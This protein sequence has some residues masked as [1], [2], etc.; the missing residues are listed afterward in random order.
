MVGRYVELEISG[1]IPL[2]FAYICLSKGESVYELL[3]V[4]NREGSFKADAR[5]L[6]KV[7]ESSRFVGLFCLQSGIVRLAL[8]RERL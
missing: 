1:S 4:R 5:K 3:S 6:K 7:H 2:P 8:R